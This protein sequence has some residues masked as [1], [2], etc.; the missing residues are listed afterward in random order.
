MQVTAITEQWSM[1][2]CF[3][4]QGLMGIGIIPKPVK[5]WKDTLL[6]ITPDFGGYH[7]QNTVFLRL[8]FYLECI[9]KAV[10]LELGVCSGADEFPK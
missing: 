1:L 9:L 7:Y 3:P 8:Y 5:D 10:G 2:H 4:F 6:M